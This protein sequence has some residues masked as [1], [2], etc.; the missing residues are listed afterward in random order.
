MRS[1]L[2]TSEECLY[3]FIFRRAAIRCSNDG[4]CSSVGR[5]PD[6]DSGRR[7]FESH[8]PP[9]GFL[10][11]QRLRQALFSFLGPPAAACYL[12]N[13]ANGAIVPGWPSC[14]RAAS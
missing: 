4:G 11:K 12:S 10:K 7:G 3:N 1:P 2:V 14:I 6:C 5:V 13:P 9:Q 8:Q